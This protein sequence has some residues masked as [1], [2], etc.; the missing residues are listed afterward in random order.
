MK[1]RVAIYCRVSTEE[2]RKKF[3]IPSQQKEC[4]ALCLRKEWTI[5]ETI[6]D[7]GYSGA[8]F[9]ERP[10][11]F[12][13]LQLV[14]Q[15]RIDIIVISD[16]DRLARPDNLVDL[17]RLQTTLISNQVKIATL[18]GN[19]IDLSNNTDWLSSTFE[20]V[21]AGWLRKKIREGAVRGIREKKSQGYFFG[22]TP[23]SGYKKNKKGL[24]VPNPKREVIFGKKKG[25]RYTIFSADEVKVIFNLY[26]KGESINSIA[27]KLNSHDS[28]IAPIL[29]RAM[30]YAGYILDMKNGREKMGDGKGKHKPL[31][32]E[33]QAKQVLKLRAENQR[34]HKISRD[35]HPS[36][37]LIKCGICGAPL[38]IKMNVKPN[39][40]YYFYICKNRKFIKKDNPKHCR[41]PTVKMTDI[42]KKV[43][44]T[45]EKIVIE[46]ENIFKM[47]TNTNTLISQNK[48]KLKRLEKELSELTKWKKRHIDLYVY[49][50]TDKEQQE[51]KTKLNKLE[52]QL[53]SKRQEIGDTDM[54][55]KVQKNAPKHHKEIRH[56]L[57]MIQEVITEANA[58]EKR[59]IIRVLFETMELKPDGSISYKLKIPVMSEGDKDFR[60]LSQ[61]SQ[62]SC[63]ISSN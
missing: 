5:V 20:S 18:S 28:T 23:P 13:L 33:L 44:K 42:E 57:E 2:Q 38:H 19:I 59:E 7:E 37:G 46:P 49:A 12:K 61:Q 63:W 32:T 25:H 36:L 52:V 8:L 39:K 3:S 50:N 27:K 14:K 29:D 55:L 30:F 41:L 54:T 4:K 34:L 53:K 21:I 22:T 16:A 62:V 51:H 43:W 40:K 24:L 10:G 9:E 31:I 56:V 48:D 26:L 47:L 15:K 6:T 11:F 45:V 60:D 1:E 17:G 58:V 35:R